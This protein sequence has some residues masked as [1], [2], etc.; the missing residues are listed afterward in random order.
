MTAERNFLGMCGA[1][2]GQLKG[3]LLGC[4]WSEEPDT[5]ELDMQRNR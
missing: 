3:R 5:A 4:D 2:G 1:E